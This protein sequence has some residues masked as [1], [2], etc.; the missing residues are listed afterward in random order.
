[1]KPGTHEKVGL[2]AST[3]TPDKLDKQGRAFMPKSD[4]ILAATKTLEPGQKES[5]KWKAP[6]EEGEY[7]YV[8]TFPG[9]FA[10]MWGKLVVTKDVDA[11]L[12]ANPQA[13]ATATGAGHEHSKK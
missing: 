9:H 3:M 10:V 6:S 4:D 12:A 13:G 5:L 1:M 2:A 7:E 8:C 11:Y